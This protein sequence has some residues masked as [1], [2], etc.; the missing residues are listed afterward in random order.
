MQF[1]TTLPVSGIE[2]RGG[3]SQPPIVVRHKEWQVKVSSGS[4]P[5]KGDSHGFEF[6]VGDPGTTYWEANYECCPTFIDVEGENV[7]VIREG[8]D[9]HPVIWNKKMIMLEF[10]SMNTINDY[11]KANTNIVKVVV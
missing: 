3:K 4:N 9:R 8:F 1:G 5:T 6:Y 2:V 11:I 10:L 7:C